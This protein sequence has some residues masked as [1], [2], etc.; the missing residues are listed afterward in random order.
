MTTTCTTLPN[1][2]III[3]TVDST[4]NM[5]RD[6]PRVLQHLQNTLDAAAE[7]CY[8]IAHIVEEPKLGLQEIMQAASRTARGANAL[9]HHRNFK[10]YLMVSD[11]KLIRLVAKG[12]NSEAFGAVPVHLFDT[13]DD[14]LAYARSSS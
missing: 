13:L 14:A 4:W 3:H 5:E 12:L 11:S 8:Y 6:L 2:P 1:E 10:A 9:L 7:P